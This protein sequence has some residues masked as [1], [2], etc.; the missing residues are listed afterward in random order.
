M[1]S[2]QNSSRDQALQQAS[3]ALQMQ[4]FD[5]ARLLATDILKSNRTDRSAVLV[6]AH[7]LLA[8]NRH[9]EAIAPLERVMRRNSDAE[10]ETLLGA[11]LC[12]SRRSA[13]GIQQLRHTAARRPPYLPA[14]Q[15][16]AG[17]LSK[18]GQLSEA[19]RTIEEA[20]TLAPASI[21]LKVDLGRLLL[22]DNDRARARET[23][24][25]ARDAAPGRPDILT[26]LGRALL[27]DGE[28]AAAADA[29]RHALGLRPQDPLARANLAACLLEMGERNG[30]ETALRAAIRGRPQMLGR[31]AYALSAS[32]HGR[33]FFR[34]SAVAKFLGENRSG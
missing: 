12:G 16:L 13:D 2:K 14:F 20:L 21:D 15:E 28:Y 7:A 19:I 6:L 32:S 26:E 30:G 5:R 1:T 31:A 25:I 23:L 9:V 11:V 22:E 34:P 29:F 27:I 18:A 17:Q 24:M 8:Q 10:I 3:L 33:F 4:Q